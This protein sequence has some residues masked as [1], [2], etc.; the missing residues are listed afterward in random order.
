MIRWATEA[1]RW[2]LIRFMQAAR[3]GSST[4]SYSD[5]DG[6]TLVDE[7]AGQLLGYVRFFL[8]RPESYVRQI[9]VHPDRRGQG[10][11][12]R[13]LL[14]ALFSVARTYGSQAIEGFH[15]EGDT[16]MPQILER[17]GARLDPGTRSRW[18]IAGGTE[19]A[20][21]WQELLSEPRT[22]SSASTHTGGQ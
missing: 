2:P 14:T 11:V 21:R 6:A 12:L 20:Q 9:V 1:D 8:G 19:E 7:E 17:A 22:T 10:L 15:G 4:Y 13:R 18:P 5:M 16:V 3:A